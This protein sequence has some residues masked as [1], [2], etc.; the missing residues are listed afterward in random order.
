MY[1]FPNTERG[2]PFVESK[3]INNT[4]MLD[5]KDHVHGQSQSTK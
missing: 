4:A 5:T 1:D 3:T 2:V